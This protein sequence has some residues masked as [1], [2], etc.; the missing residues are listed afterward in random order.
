MPLESEPRSRRAWRREVAAYLV[1]RVDAAGHARFVGHTL[2]ARREMLKVARLLP[3][4][5]VAE[6]YADP[7]HPTRTYLEVFLTPAPVEFDPGFRVVYPDR[8]TG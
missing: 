5:V 1:N 3:P 2:E 7:R 4:D 8:A 6:I